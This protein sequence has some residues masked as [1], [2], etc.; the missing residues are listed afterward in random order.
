MATWKT[1]KGVLEEINSSK[2][3]SLFYVRWTDGTNRG[4]GEAS[5]GK[6]TNEDEP[7]LGFY[8]YEP[9]DG[10]VSTVCG[11]SLLKGRNIRGM[12]YGPFGS[13]E[14]ACTAEVPPEP[15]GVGV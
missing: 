3:T 9:S 2:G 14:E 4:I 1:G 10:G 12:Y 11:E 8:D 5:V 15:V 6:Y 7:W 13:M